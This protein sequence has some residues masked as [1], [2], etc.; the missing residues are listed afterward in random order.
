MAYPIVLAVHNVIRWVVILLGVMAVF[1]SVSGIVGSKE[2]SDTDRKIGV[3]FASAIDTQL[4]L[5]LILYIFLSPITR[6]AFNDF[7]AAMGNPG[8]RFFALEH[9]F[10][11]ILAVVFAHLGTIL[12]KRAADSKA[13]FQRSA[14]WLGLAVVVV[15]L[16]I[17]W[18]RPL[19]PGL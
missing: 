1:R 6:A 5:G 2:W 8:L 19:F 7:G 14:L 12:P 9:A 17:P 10:Y 11:M 16:G 3:F 15:L 4:L 18:M 13:K